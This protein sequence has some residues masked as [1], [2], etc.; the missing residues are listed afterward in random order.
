[1]KPKLQGLW[2]E[3]AKR[4]AMLATCRR[5]S[6]GCVLT[7]ADGEQMFSFGY[8]GMYRGGPNECLSPEPGQCG[9]VHAE[10]NAIAKL[11]FDRDFVAFVTH[12]PCWQCAT[13]LIN[14]DR[15][16]GVFASKLYR[17]QQ[18]WDLLKSRVPC[19]ILD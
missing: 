19:E 3:F 4:V 5:L 8:N 12:S 9:C 13:L 16:V 6:V 11:H 10:M 15:L 18:G 1:M 7:S 17:N 2:M 14:T